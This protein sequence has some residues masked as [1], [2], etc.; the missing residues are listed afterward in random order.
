MP[1]IQEKLND[2]IEDA[3]AMEKNVRRQLDSLS[4]TTPDDLPLRAD[5]E[6]HKEET[7][8][9]I[10]RLEARMEARDTRAAMKDVTAQAGAF[11]K[12][13]ADMA[14]RDKAG[15]NARDAYVTEHFEIASYEML[16]RVAMRAGDQETAQ[17]ARDNR[18]EEQE[19]A[20]RI[21]S[22]WD[23]IVGVSLSEEGV[24]APAAEEPRFGR[25]APAGA[26]E[27]PPPPGQAGGA[28][29][30]SAPL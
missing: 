25:E 30:G 1:D 4:S 18:A 15:K 7:D 26:G 28:T 12:G 2:Y 24:E 27:Q 13:L 23:S 10:Q 8:R 11:F 22:H 21:A 6:H 3:H 9:H 16:E 14:R 5:I 17:V 19:M 29:P 20:R